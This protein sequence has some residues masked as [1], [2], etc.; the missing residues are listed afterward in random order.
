M[1]R[2]Q[3]VLSA[4]ITIKTSCRLRSRSTITPCIIVLEHLMLST[5]CNS[6][7]VSLLRCLD[8]DHLSTLSPM[9]V[10]VVNVHSH[11]LILR[12]QQQTILLSLHTMVSPC[13]CL[14]WMTS[15]LSHPG[16]PASVCLRP[17]PSGQG[18]YRRAPF[19]TTPLSSHFPSS[20]IA[21]QLTSELCCYSDMYSDM[22]IEAI[23]PSPTTFFTLPP[24]PPS[25]LFTFESLKLSNLP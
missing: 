15:T 24:P 9:N 1:D 4:A 10:Q 18:L 21:V 17:V 2:D 7:F 19:F 13:S 25:L 14:T 22:D 3:N 16:H 8:L 23:P 5:L 12:I 6:S 11:L 20:S